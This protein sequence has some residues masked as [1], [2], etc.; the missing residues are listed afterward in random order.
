MSQ[1]VQSNPSNWL[2]FVQ[3]SYYTLSEKA[4]KNQKHTIDFPPINQF[5]K[6]ELYMVIPG[7]QISVFER[8]FPTHV[9]LLI[10]INVMTAP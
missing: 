6:S 9:F 3:N 4:S 8:F 1:F 5:W 2:V 7:L 10:N